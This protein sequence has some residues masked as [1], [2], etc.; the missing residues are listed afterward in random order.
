MLGQPLDRHASMTSRD[1]ERR[2]FWQKHSR[3]S[4]FL[5]KLWQGLQRVSEPKLSIKEVSSLPGMHLPQ[6]PCQVQSLAGSSHGKGDFGTNVAMDFRAQQLDILF[7]YIFHNWSSDHEPSTLTVAR[8][9]LKKS[10]A[11]QILRPSE[12]HL[13]GTS[14]WFSCKYLDNEQVKKLLKDLFFISLKHRRCQR[15]EVVCLFSKILVL[16]QVTSLFA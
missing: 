8:S 4:H 16:C 15:L 1:G 3:P 9:P 5:N 2:K 6:Y 13:H 10:W 11:E 12:S 14:V 7:N